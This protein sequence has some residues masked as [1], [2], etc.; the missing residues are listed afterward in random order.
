MNIKNI[1]KPNIIFVYYEPEGN[2]IFLYG[3]HIIM[4]LFF[5][6]IGTLNASANNELTL[7][8]DVKVGDT[9]T[10][11]KI[12]KVSSIKKVI[13]QGAYHPVTYS[14]DLVVDNILCSVKMGSSPIWSANIWVP[15]VYAFYRLNLP[16]K[17]KNRLLWKEYVAFYM[18][19]L[20]HFMV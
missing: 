17:V 18:E 5:Q 16:T 3:N 2:N 4:N 9:V 15:I 10:T 6:N 7:P 8:K 14:T 11:N 1:D 20:Y 12:T 19:Y 13:L